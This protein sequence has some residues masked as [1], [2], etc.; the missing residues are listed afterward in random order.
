MI[1][2][3]MQQYISCNMESL[4]IARLHLVYPYI[5]FSLS[6]YFMSYGLFYLNNGNYI[7]FISLI[8]LIFTVNS[9]AVKCLTKQYIWDI[10]FNNMYEL[11]SYSSALKHVYDKRH[12]YFES[13]FKRTLN[14]D[15]IS[16][17]FFLCT[18]LII[19]MLRKMVFFIRL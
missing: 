8:F 2:I 1:Q 17:Q 12:L 14:N 4:F 19:K 9:R 16:S 10:T 15:L 5:S 13:L 7:N 6:L 3:F 18:I 11:M